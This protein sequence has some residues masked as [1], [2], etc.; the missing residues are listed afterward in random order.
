MSFCCTACLPVLPVVAQRTFPSSTFPQV[1][2]GLNL[3]MP[4][5]GGTWR[6]DLYKPHYHHHL[7]FSSS[8]GL[9]AYPLFLP[10]SHA[11]SYLPHIGWPTHTLPSGALCMPAVVRSTSPFTPFQ[12]QDPSTPGFALPACCCLL[13]LLHVDLTWDPTH[14]C[15]PTAATSFCYLF[16]SPSTLLPPHTCKLPLHSF[17][18]STSYLMMPLPSPLSSDCFPF[19]PGLDSSAYLFPFHTC[20]H[21]P[22]A[23]LT[24][25]SFC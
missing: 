25:L 18:S 20:H 10:H 15:L 23:H 5:K 11:I 6:T 1:L 8:C 2:L 22:P 16:H 7:P 12:G 9:P 19:L 3:T 4:H 17:L 24:M 13:H 21:P 14:S